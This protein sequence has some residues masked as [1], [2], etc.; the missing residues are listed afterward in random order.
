MKKAEHP[1]SSLLSNALIFLCIIYARTSAL[2][3]FRV[4]RGLRRPHRRLHRSLVLDSDTNVRK[5]TFGILKKF[6]VLDVKVYFLFVA[7]PY[8]HP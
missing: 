7:T 1:I 8:A 5:N 2:Y 4:E 6:Y 3:G